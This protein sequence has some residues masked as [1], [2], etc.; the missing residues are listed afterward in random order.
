MV[1]TSPGMVAENASISSLSF[2]V[3]IY[4]HTTVL[5]NIW[6]IAGRQRNADGGEQFQR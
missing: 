1:V 2:Q 4:R 5:M 3:Q 6:Y